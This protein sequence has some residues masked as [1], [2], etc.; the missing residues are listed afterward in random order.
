MLK[1]F[2]LLSPTPKIYTYTHIIRIIIILSV[3]ID[4]L[5]CKQHF[6]AWSLSDFSYTYYD[7][8]IRA[9]NVYICINYYPFLC[10]N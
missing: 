8:N 6:I 4:A 3:I 5:T 1:Y 10:F 9:S 2:S 7:K